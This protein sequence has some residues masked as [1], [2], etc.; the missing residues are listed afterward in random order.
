MREMRS[1]YTILILQPER[2]SPRGRPGRKWKHDIKTDLKGIQCD[3]ANLI[4]M[5]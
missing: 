2:K 3:D 4:Y 1:A 5:A